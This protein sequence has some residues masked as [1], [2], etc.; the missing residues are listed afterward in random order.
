MNMAETR[1][2]TSDMALA[3]YLYSCGVNL[4][5]IDRG[6]PRKCVFVFDSPQQELIVKWQEGRAVVNA[7]AYYN[8]Y[9]ALKRKLFRD[10]S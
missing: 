3:A 1:Y 7:L 8:A 9:Q 6:N 4:A 10:D 5:G 2:T